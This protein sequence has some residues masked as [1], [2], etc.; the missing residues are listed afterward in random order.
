M[1]HSLVDDQLW[2]LD[3]PV[4]AGRKEAAGSLPKE[5]DAVSRRLVWARLRAKALPDFP[6]QMPATLEEAY[7][8]Q[9]ASIARWPDKVSGWKVG[10]IPVSHR[11][12]LAAKRLAGP[13]FESSVFNIEPE[14]SRTV[15]IYSG[16]FAA[17]EAEFIFVLGTTIEPSKRKYSDAELVEVV[18]ALHVGAE[19]ASSPMAAINDLGPCCVVSDFGNNAGLLI[20]PPVPDWSSRSLDSLLATVKVNEILVGTA[21]A[22]AIE[23]GPLQALRFLIHLCAAREI[24]LPEGAFIS[25]GAATG[26]HV[27][28]AGSK[29]RVDF[30]ALGGFDVAFEPMTANQ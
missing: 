15:P 29:A 24:V 4:E 3:R 13:I 27:V 23:G 26:I 19:I 17:I 25:T 10:Q 20:G 6:G 5:N 2:H 1:Y 21:S 28:R 9:A 22:N 8:I 16:G 18:S 30:G 11:Q 14:S 12:R 7:A